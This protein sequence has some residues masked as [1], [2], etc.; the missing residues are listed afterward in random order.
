M[1]EAKSEVLSSR[2]PFHAVTRKRIPA[3]PKWASPTSGPH[4]SSAWSPASFHEDS[5]LIGV[6]LHQ[7]KNPA[8]HLAVRRRGRNR[9]EADRQLWCGIKGRFLG[10]VTDRLVSPRTHPILARSSFVSIV[11]CKILR[12]R[13]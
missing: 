12:N 1:S 5:P 9:E 3:A 6:W 11:L 2:C 4:S 13:P 10:M 8:A 7:Q